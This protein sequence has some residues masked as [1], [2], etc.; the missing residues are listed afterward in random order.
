MVCA[1]L[2]WLAHGGGCYMGIRTKHTHSRVRAA[3]HRTHTH[4]HIHPWVPNRY[5]GNVRWASKVFVC[6][7]FS[8]DKPRAAAAHCHHRHH[9]RNHCRHHFGCAVLC[10]WSASNGDTRPPDFEPSTC[11]EQRH[12]K[13]E[14]Y[15]V[16][17][18]KPRDARVFTCGRCSNTITYSFV[19]F[20]A[21]SSCLSKW[22]YQEKSKILFCLTCCSSY[23]V[24]AA[25]LTKCR[26]RCRCPPNA[27]VSF[28]LHFTFCSPNIFVL[29]EEL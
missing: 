4:T 2:C 7:S 28:C 5:G 29:N 15:F 16:T 1:V 3:P 19:T 17:A 24:Y 12:T 23:Y 25:K 14:Y 6:F 27:N 18:T 10:C 8:L 26:C 11:G 20:P 21:W 22:K 9:H 13:P